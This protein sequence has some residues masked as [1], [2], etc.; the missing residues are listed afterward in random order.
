MTLTT[1]HGSRLIDLATPDWCWARLSGASEGVL[2][3]RGERRHSSLAVAYTLTDRQITIP[4]ATFNDAGHL[5][6]GNEVTLEVIGHFDGDLR[7][8]VR[9]T[10][11]AE[12]VFLPDRS[13]RSRTRLKRPV[14]G[15]PV[16]A[17]GLLLTVSR[18]RGFEETSANPV[19][20]PFHA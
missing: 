19:V 10:G 4:V 12:Q 3:Y 15:A 7:W 6:A 11:F 8:V 20:R 1:D 17:D 13:G 16:G 9:A 5:A 2:S 18:I 14:H